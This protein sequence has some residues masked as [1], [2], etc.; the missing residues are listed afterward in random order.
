MPL[1]IQ[2]AT[3]RRLPMTRTPTGHSAKP[4]ASYVTTTRQGCCFG[5]PSQHSCKQERDCPDNYLAHINLPKVWKPCDEHY[6]RMSHGRKP[7]PYLTT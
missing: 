6:S 2:F 5:I 1:T 7:R 4:L 3:P